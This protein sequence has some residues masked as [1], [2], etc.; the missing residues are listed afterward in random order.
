MEDPVPTQYRSQTS[1]DS[2]EVSDAAVCKYIHNHHSAV[3]YVYT[4]VYIC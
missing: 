2:V 4:Y 1:L 3:A